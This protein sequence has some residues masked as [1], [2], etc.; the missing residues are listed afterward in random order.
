LKLTNLFEKSDDYVITGA[1]HKIK[2]GANFIAFDCY[3][4][5]LAISEEI[6]EKLFDASNY[7][8]P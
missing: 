8:A 7:I 5:I 6:H 2:D 4:M 3:G 1:L